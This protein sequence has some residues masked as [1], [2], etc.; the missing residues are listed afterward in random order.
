MRV[1][2]VDKEHRNATYICTKCKK[3]LT[4]TLHPLPNDCELTGKTLAVNCKE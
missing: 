1:F 2:S 3:G 4:V